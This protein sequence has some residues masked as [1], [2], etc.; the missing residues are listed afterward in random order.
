LGRASGKR[1]DPIGVPIGDL[2]GA[3]EA[4]KAYGGALGM[5]LVTNGEL[6]AH[7][8]ESHRADRQRMILK[9]ST[10]AEERVRRN[11]GI[12]PKLSDLGQGAI[13]EAI[14]AAGA[15]QFG[16]LLVSESVFLSL[17]ARDASDKA[18]RATVR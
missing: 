4:T 2:R 9:A 12:L 3:T 7:R 18:K 17:T 1:P 6:D 8:E 13:G 16:R 14:E 15:W 11:V 10:W 5:R